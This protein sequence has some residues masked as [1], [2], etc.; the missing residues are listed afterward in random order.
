MAQWYREIVEILEQEPET[1][2]AY[3]YGVQLDNIPHL[4]RFKPRFRGVFLRLLVV[5]HFLVRNLSLKKTPRL[6]S[7]IRPR[8]L[9]YAGTINQMNALDSTIDSLRVSGESVVAV[10]KK[11]FVNTA[12][13]RVR[14]QSYSFGVTD[15]AKAVLLMLIRGRKLYKSLKKIQTQAVDWH[16][17]RFCQ[18]Y[19][20]LAYFYDLLKGMRPEFVVTANDHNVPNRC[21][22]A[23]AHRLGI[24]TVY[25]QHA[26]VSDLFP[27][28]RVNYAFLDGQAAL[29]IYR[30]CER[31]QPLTR[32][33]VPTPQ[34]FLTGQKKSLVCS[35]GQEKDYLG[36]ALNALDDP[37]NGDPVRS[38]DH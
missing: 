25:M 18:V 7:E 10:A 15:E 13:R 36:V 6:S 28:L 2:L 38:K 8:F 33:S 24:K 17:N 23:V 27:A 9:V 21:I 26:S 5:F 34:V 20:Y 14:Y 11:G 22:L 1:W 29:D 4:S 32:R 30:E 37:R 12:E 19:V 35:D 3:L 31:N 16:F